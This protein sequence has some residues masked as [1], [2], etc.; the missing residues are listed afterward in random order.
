MKLDDTVK[1]YKYE[2]KL[3]SEN[4]CTPEKTNILD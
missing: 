4:N 3:L 2:E 1:K